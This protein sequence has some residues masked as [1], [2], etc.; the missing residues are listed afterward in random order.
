MIN[1][2][3]FYIDGKWIAP[4]SG[5]DSHIFKTIDPA[6]ENV[7]GQIALGTAIDVDRAVAAARRAFE[8][9]SMTDRSYRIDLLRRI[10]DGFSSRR[11]D[12]SKAMVQEMGCPDW[13]ADGGQYEMPAMHLQKAIEVLESFAFEYHNA[14]TL[15][16][17]H[18]I[19]RS[20][21]Q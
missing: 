18:G 17:R 1:L 7:S 21:P 16:R 4:E 6:T 10:A 19:G 5:T 3:T 8:S 2:S 20:S 12:L 11:A 13:L 15:V 14:A 9:Y